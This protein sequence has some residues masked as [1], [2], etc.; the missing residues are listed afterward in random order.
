MLIEG[1]PLVVDGDAHV[2]EALDTVAELL[3][4]PYR[5]RA[6]RLLTDTLGLTR[7]L[8]EGRLYPDP[9]LRQRHRAGVEGKNLGGSQPGATDPRARID[10]LDADEIDVQ[11]VYGS[12]GLSLSTIRDANFAA[13]F[14]RALNDYYA[15]FCATTPDR[16]APM[17]A[18]PVQDV[19]AAVVELRRA[20]VERGHLGGTVPPNVEGKNLDHPDFAP[21]FAEA[22]ALDAP[23]S[24]HWGN[25]AHLH[26]AGTE[27]FDTHFMVHALGHPVEQM[28]ALASVLG[29]GVLDEHPTLRIGFLEAGC[30]WVPY[31]VERLDE[32]YERRGGELPRMAM[33][34]SQ[35]LAQG[36]CFVTAEPDERLVPQA[37]EAFGEGAVMFA[38][39]YPHT[40]STFPYAVKKLRARDDLT[41]EIK[42]RLLGANALVYYGSRL[43]RRL[44]A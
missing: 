40:D 4:E 29:G 2:N 36:R 20:V 30:G 21:L 9:R 34:P 38:S 3:E 16:L 14:A 19:P 15:D 22:A 28:I 33:S 37:V 27:R 41:P 5:S 18:L 24:V 39:D 25:G 23:I 43:R 32:H 10:D 26:A 35:Y 44:S 8:L 13:A 31:W 7:I 12:L 17:A 1:A 11:I 6:P 42:Q